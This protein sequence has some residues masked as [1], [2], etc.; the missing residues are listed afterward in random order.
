MK[1]ILATVEKGIVLRKMD[2][3]AHQDQQSPRQSIP[4]IRE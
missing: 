3:L 1:P 4:A 2:R